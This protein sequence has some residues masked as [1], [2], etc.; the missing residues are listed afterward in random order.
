MPFKHLILGLM[1][2]HHVDSAICG[3]YLMSFYEYCIIKSSDVTT[4]RT[5][6]TMQFTV[7]KPSIGKMNRTDCRFA[8]VNDVKF[9][10]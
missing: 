10:I 6:I 7:K 1:S 8:T 2:K 3:T 9:S 4:E 5:K